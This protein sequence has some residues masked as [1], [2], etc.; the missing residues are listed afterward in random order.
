MKPIQL[1]LIFLVLLSSGCSFFVPEPPP[2]PKAITKK[3]AVPQTSAQNNLNVSPKVTAGPKTYAIDN[4]PGNFK[5]EPSLPTFRAEPLIAP[6]DA[7]A[8]A[9]QS[10]AGQSAVNP[11]LSLAAQGVPSNSSATNNTL[12]TNPAQS[13]SQIAANSTNSQNLSLTPAM[14]PVILEDAAIPNGTSPAVIAL[15]SQADHNSSKGDLSSA[16]VDMERALRI[17][18]RNATITYKLAQLRLK[19]AKPQQAEEL[20]GKA[21]LLAAGDLE[22]KRKSW[23]LIAEARKLQQNF[24]GA[25]EAKIKAESFFGR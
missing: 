25:K 11:A 7:P 2:K 21:A 10:A 20:A 18:S 19:Q 13:S 23:L 15:I 24:N 14:T 16:V 1:C 22:L 4:G 8:V 3:P 12:A 6:V 9:P 5:D 17:D